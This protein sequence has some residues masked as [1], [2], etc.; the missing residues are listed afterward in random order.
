MKITSMYIHMELTHMKII[1]MYI[2]MEITGMY[3]HTEITGMYMH[4]ENTHKLNNTSGHLNAFPFYL[5][6]IIFNRC[7]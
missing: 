7:Q 5:I 6:F 3:I 1:S 4:M 2:H